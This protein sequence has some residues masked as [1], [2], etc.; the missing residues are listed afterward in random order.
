MRILE[1]SIW[2][3]GQPLQNILFLMG[4]G[5]DVELYVVV[6]FGDVEVGCSVRGETSCCVIRTSE[7]KEGLVLTTRL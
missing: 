5:L 7:P 1:T 2:R 3:Q 6:E 4:G